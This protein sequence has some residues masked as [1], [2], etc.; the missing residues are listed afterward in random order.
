MIP[1]SKGRPI[2]FLVLGSSLTHLTV[3]EAKVMG[4]TEPSE[5]TEIVHITPYPST[6]CIRYGVSG[7][8]EG[9]EVV[10]LGR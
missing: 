3:Y 5:G 1:I 10:G 7:V 2:Q 6:H 8:N 9:K 4:M